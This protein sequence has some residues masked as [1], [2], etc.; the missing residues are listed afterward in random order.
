M[1]E[2]GYYPAGAE[3][4][5][6]APWNEVEQPE[7]DFDI[8]VHHTLKKRVRV[9]T[10]NYITEYVEENGDRNVDTAE[11]DW[12]DAFANSHFS[13]AEM[14][15]ILKE[16]VE[17][18]LAMTGTNTKKGKQLQQLLNDLDGWE[19]DYEEYEEV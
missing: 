16:Y 1:K 4:D 10:N 7:M 11:T 3:Y 2:S 14:L 13:I 6:S 17:S 12:S 18:D 19:L 9:A 5:P 15:Q 8:E